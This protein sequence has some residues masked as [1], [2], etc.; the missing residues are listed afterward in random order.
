VTRAAP[1][2]DAS[3]LD[4]RILAAEDSA[5]GAYGMSGTNRHLTVHSG[6]GS[7]R[8][9]IREFGPADDP[10]PI[11]LMHGISSANVLAAPLLPY[12]SGR[13][14]LALDW[15]GHGLSDPCVLGPRVNLR[16]HV[17][18]VITSALDRL[19]LDVADLLGHSLG[20]QFALYTAL[21]NPDRVRRIGLLGAPGASLRGVRPPAA[22]RP[23]AVRG[24]GPKLLAVPMPD[25]MF[26]RAQD[27][28]L[29]P[30][31]LSSA[32]PELTTALRL[33]SGRAGNAASIA[34][35]F[36]SLLK[37]GIRPEVQ[38]PPEDLARIRQRVLM[39]WGDRDIFLSPDAGSKSI[40]S[41]PDVRFV[42]IV[43]AGHAP[44]LNA[45]DMVGAAVAEH[46]G[47]EPSAPIMH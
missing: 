20:A 25:K 32:K 26:D 3:V 42:R 9:R 14:I 29:G 15:P 27:T 41:I 10:V 8:V 13:R 44:W 31:A 24:L 6:T 11:V 40:V 39:A 22:M 23:L 34:S 46:L 47:T 33:I 5:Y 36:R 35:Y 38:L 18:A 4:E 30:G 2:I 12:L 37:V 21:D 7:V 19:D 16:A 45:P 43:G 1:D 17:S 28:V